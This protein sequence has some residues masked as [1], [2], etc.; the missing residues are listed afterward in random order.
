M[1]SK[2]AATT[3]G[4]H[5]GPINWH[6]SAHGAWRWLM[7]YKR[8]RL[9]IWIQFYHY[10]LLLSASVGTAKHSADS[11]WRMAL[12]HPCRR[13]GEI[14]KPHKMPFG[15]KKSLQREPVTRPLLTSGS[16]V[17]R[18]RNDKIIHTGGYRKIHSLVPIF[19]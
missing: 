1:W 17:G 8:P 9:I 12:V 2:A 6:Q 15:G 18:P 14:A 3:A 16:P 10:S 13:G 4:S 19:C 11:G 5:A 7:S